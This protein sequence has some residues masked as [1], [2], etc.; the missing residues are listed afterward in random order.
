MIVQKID[1][2]E[3]LKL[4]FALATLDKIY[5]EKTLQEASA[6]GRGHRLDSIFANVHE[7]FRNSD[8]DQ[9]TWL[10]PVS[11]FLWLSKYNWVIPHEN[12]IFMVP[13]MI[14][15]AFYNK[16]FYLLG[17]LRWRY[18]GAIDRNGLGVQNNP[19]DHRI[20]EFRLGFLRNSRPIA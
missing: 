7:S 5:L 18:D 10:I 20:F 9:E 11:Y 6:Q 15:I 2:K 4:I 17:K 3:F 13:H 1:S 16:I 19:R 12:D 14:I 8:L